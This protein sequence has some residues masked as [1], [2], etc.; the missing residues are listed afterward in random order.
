MFPDKLNISNSDDT[1]RSR[2]LVAGLNQW[3]WEIYFVNKIVSSLDMDLVFWEVESV[4]E[5][6]ARNLFPQAEIMNNSGGKEK[7]FQYFSKHDWPLVDPAVVK[8]L[9]VHELELWPSFLRNAQLRGWRGD[10]SLKD[11]YHRAITFRYYF[12]KHYRP[13]VYLFGNVPTGFYAFLDYL[14]CKRLSV[15]TVLLRRIEVPGFYAMPIMSIEQPGDYL[16]ILESEPEQD[17]KISN[18]EVQD[19]MISLTSNYDQA[20]PQVYG[21]KG[22]FGA[23]YKLDKR[24]GKLKESEFW[25]PRILKETFEQPCNKVK[26]LVRALGYY[27]YRKFLLHAYNKYVADE[28]NTDCPY[29][30]VNLHY[31]PEASGGYICLSGVDDQLVVTY[32]SRGLADLC[33]GAP[34]TLVE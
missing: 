3:D 23:A 10:M 34:D 8:E 9:S 7:R 26:Y 22:G 4:T 30:L 1:S 11:E 24:T 12:I 28:L 25:I 31:Q 27:S 16:R 18:R 33:Q 19:Y 2:L 5:N 29:I 21:R 15:T 6:L 17:P 13:D 20:M 14:L 32:S